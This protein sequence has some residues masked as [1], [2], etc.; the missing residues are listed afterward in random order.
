MHLI[1][2]LSLQTDEQLIHTACTSWW[3]RSG[4]L[5]IGLALLPFGGIGA[6]VWAWAWWQVQSSRVWVTSRRLV[7]QQGLLDRRIVEVRVQRID[8]VVVEQTL[9]QRL[10]GYGTVDVG[11]GALGRIRVE[12]VSAPMVLRAAI[13]ETQALLH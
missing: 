7:W 11:A 3:S 1:P 13:V 12:E 8:A 5:A 9:N 2:R 6:L 10:M 4:L